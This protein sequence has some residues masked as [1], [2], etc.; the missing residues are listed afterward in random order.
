V[1]P[2]RWILAAGLTLL[3]LP[4]YVGLLPWA[5]DDAFIHLRVADNLAAG[6]GPYF[7]EGQRVNASSAP[8]W[9]WLLAV[10]S[11]A[12]GSTVWVAAINALAT[13]A[14]ALVFSAVID[15]LAGRPGE[16]WVSWAFAL[17]Y[18]GCVQFAGA[19]LMEVPV[20][21]LVLGGA[22]LGWL[23]RTP[24]CFALFS[25]ACFLRVEFAL[26]AILFLAAATWSGRIDRFRSWVA[27]I[28]GALPFVVY[29]LVAFGSLVPH[30]VTAKARVYE[31]AVGDAW[32]LLAGVAIPGTGAFARSAFGWVCF[33]A[34]L[35]VVGL[36]YRALAARDGWRG[37]RADDFGGLPLAL[38]GLGGLG[39][40]VTYLA[41]AALVF[42]WY[43]PLFVVPALVSVTALA[44]RTGVRLHAL[45]IVV[46]ALTPFAVE[47]VPSLTAVFAD[48][49]ASYRY[50]AQNARVRKYRE[51]GARLSR[52]YPG[53][54]LLTSE[55]GGLG[56]G[57]EGE[58]LDGAGL[59]SPRAL[60]HHPMQ[61]PRQRRAGHIGAIPAAF[62][63][64]EM[65]ELIVSMDIFAEDLLKSGWRDHYRLV[66]EPLFLPADRAAGAPSVL[67]GS[68]AMNVFIKRD[69]PRF[70]SR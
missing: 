9:T 19:G 46:F 26:F 47:L 29:L 5:F 4:L 18:C 27:A 41:T 70:E 68:T 23:A 42:P 62:V 43:V 64:D 61:V 69:L 2:A 6:A 11:L 51:L 32:E 13:V 39:I 31:L 66:R 8:A 10:L 44:R 28:L 24:W 59:I 1:T 15:R 17:A 54:R 45:A 37:E 55:V 50:F 67:W 30:T 56:D 65:P 40:V 49:P 60:A 7:N 52:A 53:A 48:R 3:V 35:L 38:L 33:P 36:A 22:V 57:F 34:T 12:G 58:I 20:A 14:G 63:V 16:A 25:L 21:L